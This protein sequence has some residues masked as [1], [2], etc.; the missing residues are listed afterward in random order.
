MPELNRPKI[1]KMLGFFAKF[2]PFNTPEFVDTQSISAGP[3]K[4]VDDFWQRHSACRP[5]KY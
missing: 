5:E 2:G 4:T 3:F 1:N